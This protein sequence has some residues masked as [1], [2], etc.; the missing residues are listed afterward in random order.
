MDE[1]HMHNHAN[2]VN[3]PLQHRAM[4]QSLRKKKKH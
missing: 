2:T 3:V 1:A 4:Q